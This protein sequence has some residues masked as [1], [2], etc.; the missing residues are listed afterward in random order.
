MEY[1]KRSIVPCTVFV[2]H[3]QQASINRNVRRLNSS[4]FLLINSPP[5][6]KD[7]ME[8]IGLIAGAGGWKKLKFKIDIENSVLRLLTFHFMSI[9]L[10]HSL[11][12]YLGGSL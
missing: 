3:E 2:L 6:A 9:Y 4:L 11:L 8:S 12:F 7:Y 1:E 5:V 10:N